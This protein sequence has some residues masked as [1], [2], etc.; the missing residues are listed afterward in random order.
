MITRASRFMSRSP[1]R[2]SVDQTSC[3]EADRHHRQHMAG[4]RPPLDDDDQLQSHTL[5][6]SRRQG[7][8]FDALLLLRPSTGH[9]PSAAVGS[10][11]LLAEEAGF[12]AALMSPVARDR[13][14]PNECHWPAA[15]SQGERTQIQLNTKL[16]TLAPLGSTAVEGRCDANRSK[17]FGRNSVS[18]QLVRALDH[19]SFQQQ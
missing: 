16:P 17:V 19:R 2:R 11:T 18:E 5:P 9:R 1:I 8:I 12:R 4:H 7:S 13:H 15:V 14:R 6:T 10:E 3:Q